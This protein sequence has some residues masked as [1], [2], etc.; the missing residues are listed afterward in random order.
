METKGRHV[1]A[2]VSCHYAVVSP[3]RSG[4]IMQSFHP[5]GLVSLGTASNEHGHPPHS[6]LSALENYK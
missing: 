6:R 1:I 4:V 2:Q 5:V 3:G